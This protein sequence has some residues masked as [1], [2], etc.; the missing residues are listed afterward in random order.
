VFSHEVVDAKVAAI[1]DAVEFAGAVLTA[2][3][4][5]IFTGHGTS[6][7]EHRGRSVR[8]SMSDT[9]MLRQSDRLK[10]LGTPPN[11]EL[12]RKPMNPAMRA[13]IA[14]SPRTN[15]PTSPAD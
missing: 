1:A 9:I 4:R 13:M 15:S 11:F 14:A 7:T 3:P 8:L 6:I 12:C 5:E 2:E 10:Q